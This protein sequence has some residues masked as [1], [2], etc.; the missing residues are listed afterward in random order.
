MQGKL[1]GDLGGA[2]PFLPGLFNNYNLLRATFCYITH[3][4]WRLN[5]SPLITSCIHPQIVP[6]G[7]A[8]QL[9][10]LAPRPGFWL[11]ASIHLLRCCKR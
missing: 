7:S 8:R 2:L 5:P 10:K 1:R 11:D 3:L 6:W 9:D 4:I